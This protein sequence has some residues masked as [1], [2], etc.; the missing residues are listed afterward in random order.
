MGSAW[1]SKR[2]DI[3][4]ARLREGVRVYGLE[5]PSTGFRPGLKNRYKPKSLFAPRLTAAKA[6]REKPA[7]RRASWG[8][9]GGTDGFTFRELWVL[10]RAASA[11][12]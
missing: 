4:T 8:E 11:S 2:T 12:P 6:K 9:T 7:K 5:K 1:V 3:G 10:S